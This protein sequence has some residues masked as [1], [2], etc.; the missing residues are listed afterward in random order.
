MRHVLVAGAI[1]LAAA[2]CSTHKAPVQQPMG[3][4]STLSRA[5]TADAKFCEHKVPEENCVR[6]HP[7]LIQRFKDVGDWCPE[8]DI[9]ES[10]CLLC[11]PELTFDPLPSARADADIRTLSAKGEDVPSLEAHAVPGKVTVF[12]FYADWCAPCVEIDAHMIRLLNERSDI[13]YRKLNVV[14]WDT[15]IAKR[16]MSKAAKL[17][18]VIVYGK[19]GKVVAPVVGFNLKAL[20]EAIATGAAR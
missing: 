5:K 7:E 12:D 15:P 16:Y 20:D 3:T 6:H 18:M 9:P 14:G 19:D 8:H 13:A 17:P 2:S 1:A 11:H 4:I 10:Q